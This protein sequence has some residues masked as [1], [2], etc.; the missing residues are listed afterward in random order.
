MRLATLGRAAGIKVPEGAEDLEVSSIETDSRMAKKG[1]LFVCIRGLHTDSHRCIRDAVEQGAAAVLVEKGA[2]FL[3][4]QDGAVLLEAEDTRSAAAFLY[5]AW[6]GFPADRL[7][8]I[9]VTGTNGKTSVTHM[10]RHILESAFI[11]CGVIGTIG[12]ECCGK[13]LES[14]SENR[15]A[16]MTTPDPQ[17]LYRL[18]AQMADEGAEYVLME[19]SSHALALGKLAPLHF[20]LAIF[21][22][23]TQDHLDFHKTMDEYADAK[24]ML[25]AKSRCSIL[26]VDSPYADRMRRRAVGR[27]ITCSSEARPADYTA[28]LLPGGER[29]GVQYR[30][31]AAHLSLRMFCPIPGRFSMTNSMQ[32]AVAAMELGIRPSS[33]KEAVASLGGIKGRMERVPL[34]VD[35]DFTVLI[36]YAHTPDALENLLRTAH[37]ICRAGERIVLLFGC[38]GERDVGKRPIMGRIA[39]D[40]ADLVIL[41]SDNSRGEDPKKIREQILSGMDQTREHIVIP[42]RKQAIEYAILTARQGDLILLAGKGHEEYEILCGERRRFSER[43]IVEKALL[44][45]RGRSDRRQDASFPKDREGGSASERKETDLKE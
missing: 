29:E 28:S 32:A 6:Y 31:E 12:C 25:F 24:A 15:L 10:L 19:A 4:L 13:R 3:L 39:S 1:S 37:E 36:D 22:N 23:L 21:T 26:C 5:H 34:G 40:Y 35:A 7:K 27:V 38:G 45:R 18:L 9:G 41:T 20:E 11:P 42:D 8:L 43:E 17:V 44:E 16:N 33:V 2:S 14:S 30:L